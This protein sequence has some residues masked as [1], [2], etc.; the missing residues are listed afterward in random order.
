MKREELTKTFM[1]I[2]NFKKTFGRHGL[3]K[4]IAALQGLRDRPKTPIPACYI[5]C[6]MV[7]NLEEY[8]PPPYL[9]ITRAS[10]TFKY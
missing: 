5:S 6:G 10:A 7:S 8:P 3:Y 2:S 9:L 4:N 1:M